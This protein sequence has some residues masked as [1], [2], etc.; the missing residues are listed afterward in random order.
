MNTNQPDNNEQPS[1]H[2]RRQRYSGTHPKTFQQKYK[3]HN[4]AAHPELRDKLRAK[5]KTPA[6]S[7]IPVLLEEVLEILNPQPGQIVADC[8][9][10]YGGHSRQFIK[11]LGPTGKLIAFDVDGAELERTQ[12]RLSGS[13]TPISFYHS[14]FAGIANA[15]KREQIDGFD[16]IFADLGVS[17]M[18][19]DDAERGISYKNEGPLDMRMDKRLKQ[20]GADLINSLPEE[21]IAKALLEYSDEPDNEKIARMIVA[22]RSVQP[23]TT[24]S[25]LIRLVFAVKGLTVN[26]WKKQQRTS[27]FGS[28]HPAARTFQSLRI[29]VN[30]E[31]GSLKELLRIAPYCLRPGGRI[32]IISFHSGEDRLVKQSFRDGAEN[33]VYEFASKKAVVPRIKEVIAN[34]RCASAKFRWAVKA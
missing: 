13:E 6:G 12:K 34:P 29:L 28:L 22:Q 17:S 15:L 27:K 7:H 11:R 5:G 23:I 3:E 16:V 10:G 24:V 32:G 30:D 14:N 2:R 26:S 20:T 25:Q 18:Q 9:L 1:I 8:T 31:L 33:G 4:L 21:E 19:I